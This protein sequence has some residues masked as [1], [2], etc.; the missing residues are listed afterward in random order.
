MAERVLNGK[1]EIS[2]LSME[3][4]VIGWLFHLLGLQF[5]ICEIGIMI[6]LALYPRIV[7]NS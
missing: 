5:F 4:V 2:I 7:I 1:L 6:L 3:C